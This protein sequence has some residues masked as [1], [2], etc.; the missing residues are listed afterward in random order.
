[1]K[2]LLAGLLLSLTVVTTASWAEAPQPTNKT[3]RMATT[4]STEN[5]GLLKYLLP[6]FTEK[7]GYEVQVIAVGSGKALKMGEDGDVDV[8][9]S[10][11]P[12]AE[13]EFVAKGFA[14]K[15]Y[16]VMYNDFI[17]LGTAADPAEVAKSQSTAEAFKKIADKKAIFISR[18]D[19][20]GTHKKEL[21]LWEK[22]EIKP[23]GEWY[24]EAGQSME[25]VIQMSGQLEAY[26]L[27]DR[28]TWLAV[29]KDSPLKIVYE[30]EKG[31]LN[32]YG[33][34]AV[35]P[36]RYPDINNVGAQTLINWMISPEGQTAVADFK[37]DGQT[38]FTPSADPKE[39]EEAAKAFQTVTVKP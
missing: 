34:M 23:A 2:P 20:S 32:P 10:H 33:I 25:N 14:E 11:A 37:V 13:E 30:G 21:S 17:V 26:T 35:S 3:I 15:R 18:G 22:A 27:S 38:L 8:V 28:G 31:L 36:K 16:G 24:R 5:S 29:K 12:K 1:M 6:K 7:T 4:T 39:S 9:L 19:D